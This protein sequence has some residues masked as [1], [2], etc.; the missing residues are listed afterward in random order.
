MSKSNVSVINSCDHI[1]I[2]LILLVNVHLLT[3]KCETSD[4]LPSPSHIH[5]QTCTRDA[6]PAGEISSAAS[7]SGGRE[8]G[9]LGL[10]SW[11]PEKLPCLCK[12]ESLDYLNKAMKLRAFNQLVEKLKTI[13]PTATKDTVF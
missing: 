9:S 8:F 6:S 13:D 11:P 10:D 2:S 4:P 5:V 3:K 1:L 7:F 12:I